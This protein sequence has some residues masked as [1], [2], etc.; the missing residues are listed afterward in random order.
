MLPT[1]STTTTKIAQRQGGK[2]ETLPLTTVTRRDVIR[3]L[4]GKCSR[5][6]VDDPRIL[7]ID[8][9]KGRGHRE[10]LIIKPNTRQYYQLVIRDA[11]KHYQLLCCNCN[12]LKRVEEGEHRWKPE[13]VKLS[14][15]FVVLLNRRDA[16]RLQKVCYNSHMRISIWIRARLLEILKREERKHAQ[17]PL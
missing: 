6:P 17:H 4:G 2:D 5:C 12:F 8:H 16:L 11:G 3:A 14:Y 9:R 13:P 15:R 7:Q 10:S 1:H